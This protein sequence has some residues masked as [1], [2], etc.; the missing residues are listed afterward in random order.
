M[1]NRREY[2][3]R[4]L[5]GLTLAVTLFGIVATAASAI[6]SRR[7]VWNASSSVPIGLYWRID[8]RPARGDLV[9]A[10][11]P[12][13]ARRV[14]AER[15]YLPIEV[16]LVKRVAAMDGDTVCAMGDAIEINGETVA[17]RLAFDGMRRPMPHWTGC[18]TLRPGEVLLLM[19]DVPDSFDGR[20]FGIS[21]RYDIIGLLVP[22]WTR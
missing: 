3:R 17:R 7:L 6:P 15:H 21:D 4:A 10:W 20:Y 11:A 19:G 14:A 2:P 18:Q 16:P 5:S 22:L 8:G 13:W 12:L 1:R 9:L